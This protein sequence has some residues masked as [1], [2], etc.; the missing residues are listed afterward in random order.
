[1]AKLDDA[2][3]LAAKA[4]VVGLLLGVQPYEANSALVSGSAASSSKPAAVVLECSIAP[5]AVA[6]SLAIRIVN[7]TSEGI[8]QGASLYFRQGV[9]R[10]AE[11]TRH[12]LSEGLVPGKALT[13]F[14]PSVT[15]APGECLAWVA[16]LSVSDTL[17]KPIGSTVTLGD[18]FQ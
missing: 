7:T 6:D 8:P 11:G 13:L 9:T 3:R 2:F 5:S 10:N 12:V 1:M 17:E 18:I 15:W 16:R 4:L 14:V